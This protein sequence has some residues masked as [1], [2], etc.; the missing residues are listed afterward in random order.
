MRLVARFLTLLLALAVPLPGLTQDT[1]E[2]QT[3][4]V[5]DIVLENASEFILLLERA[6]QL[7]DPSS[8]QLNQEPRVT[9]VLHGPVLNSL[10][11]DNYVENK[12]IADLAAR[13]TAMQVIEVKACRTWMGSQ[14]LQEA[15]LLP[16]VEVVPYAAAEVKK[17]VEEKEY[18]FF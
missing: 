6:E 15:S 3:Q 17:L 4:Y 11:R 14:G 8:L 10:L 16:F 12:E 7:L 18:V 2:S 9:F 5:A 1:T 13:L